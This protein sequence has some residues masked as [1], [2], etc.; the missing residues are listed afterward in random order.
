MPKNPQ[1]FPNFQAIYPQ[2]ALK[3]T[4]KR[5]DKSL[6]RKASEIRALIFDVDGVMTD[7]KIIYSSSGDEIKEFNVRDGIII[8]SLKKA[9]FIVGIISGRESSAVT[10]RATELK[11]DFCHQAIDDKAWACGQIMKHHQ[12]KEKEI[13]YIGDDINDLPVF[14]LAGLKACPADACTEVLDIADLV[15]K[16][17]GGKGVVREVADFLLATNKKSKSGK[18]K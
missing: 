8:S 18:E 15:T 1:R 9:G 7:G 3:T 11:L 12:L 16:A 14:N 13:A 6:L 2:K 10:R 4:Q 17:K 5:I